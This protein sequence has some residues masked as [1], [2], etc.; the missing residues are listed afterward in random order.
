MTTRLA[1][2]PTPHG[3]MLPTS[4]L[5]APPPAAHLRERPIAAF[6]SDAGHGLSQAGAAAVGTSLRRRSG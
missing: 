4:D 2:L 6:A 1:P 5:A 3:Q